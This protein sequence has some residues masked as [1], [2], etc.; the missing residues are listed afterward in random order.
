MGLRLNLGSGTVPL[1][2]F[3]NVDALPDAPGVDVVADLSQPLPF[4][5]GAADLVYAAHVL[6][7]FPTDEVP[8]LLADW[9]RV[10]RE[11]GILLVAVPDLDVIARTIVDERPGWFTPPHG[12]WLGAIYGGQKDEYDFHKTGFTAP[13]LSWLLDEAGF[14]SVQKVDR[15]RELSVSD[16]S[17]SPIPFGSNMSLNLRAV[18]GGRPL[19]GELFER[20]AV[21]RMLDRLDFVLMASMMVSTRLRSRVMATRRRRLEGLLGTHVD[22]DRHDSRVASR[23]V[24]DPPA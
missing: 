11:G 23:G 22:S 15:F 21:E 3:T 8:R 2:G 4:A 6:E 20:T 17:F 14:G 1:E 12:P 18:A 24:A 16:L 5:N 10:L 7:H 13:W 19:P 9:R